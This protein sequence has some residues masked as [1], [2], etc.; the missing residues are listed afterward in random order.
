M[1]APSALPTREVPAG[2]SAEQAI[3]LSSQQTY[4]AQQV[5][6]REQLAAALATIW[7]VTTA[8]PDFSPG[9]AAKFVAQILPVSVGAQRAMSALTM[10]AMNS[11]IQPPTPVT[12]PPASV[13]G[14]A[15][16]GVDPND[17]YARPFREIKWRLSQGKT[18]GE[19]VAAGQRR[20][21]SIVETDLQLAH[22]HTARAVL[23]QVAA[24]P[25]GPGYL[26]RARERHERRLDDARRNRE[27][28]RRAPAPPAQPRDRG[29]VVG[30]RRVLGNNPNHCAMCLIA[31]TQRYHV[32]DLMPIHPGCHCTVQELWSSDGFTRDTQVLDP[33]FLQEIHNAVA[34]DLGWDY[35]DAG[36]RGPASTTNTKGDPIAGYK[37][38]IITNEHGELGPVLGIR[39]HNFQGP[40]DIPNLGHTRVNPLTGDDGIP[41]LDNL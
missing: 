36:G 1:T 22:T 11:R 18:L 10:A 28:R 12:V 4:A 19:A 31:S 13:T 39:G 30:Y 27:L 3:L 25:P 26:D 16:R 33:G 40:R 24:A 38:I 6:L 29:T 37:N 23:Q 8:T 21:A 9:A 32:G 35:V 34:R 15:L 14:A 5:A 41:N 2:L 7:A 20:A 17:Y